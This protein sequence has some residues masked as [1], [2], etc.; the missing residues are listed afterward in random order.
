MY[1]KKNNMTVQIEVD[2]KLGMQLTKYISDTYKY[3]YFHIIQ[4]SIEIAFISFS[5][6]ISFN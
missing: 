5:N 6:K 3:R 2:K 1:E 4:C